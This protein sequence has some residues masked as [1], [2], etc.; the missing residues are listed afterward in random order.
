MELYWLRENQNLFG[1]HNGLDLEEEE[2]KIIVLGRI[3]YGSIPKF[4]K[5]NIED[6]WRI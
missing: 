6:N 5:I 3:G 2:S 1:R 4:H